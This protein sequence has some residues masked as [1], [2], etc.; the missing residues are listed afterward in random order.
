[1]DL[2][3]TNDDEFDLFSNGA[4]LASLDIVELYFPMP[5]ISERFARVMGKSS[6]LAQIGWRVGGTVG[7]GISTALSNGTDRPATQYVF[8]VVSGTF[9]EYGCIS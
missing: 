8:R 9:R 3:R 5:L 6:R 4:I 7:A 1:M 2:K